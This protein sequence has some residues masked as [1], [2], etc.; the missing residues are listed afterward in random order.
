MALDLLRAIFV[1]TAKLSGTD[2]RFVLQRLDGRLFGTLGASR[3][4]GPVLGGHGALVVSAR[5]AQ[6]GVSPDG[7]GRRTRVPR[8]S[9]AGQP[10][11]RA[12]AV[13]QCAPAPDHRVRPP[14]G[15]TTTTTTTFAVLQERRRRGR[16]LR[17]GHGQ[18]G[19]PV[20]WRPSGRPVPLR[21]RAARLTRAQ[22][23]LGRQSRRR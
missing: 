7:N 8:V 18:G 16:I 2:E 10:G 3:P 14:D 11:R 9:Q 19:R 4:I 15:P 6:S 12:R 20:R 23:V 22:A 5:C 21:S 17:G 1:K 13:G